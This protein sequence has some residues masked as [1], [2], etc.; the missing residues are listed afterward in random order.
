MKDFIRILV[1]VAAAGLLGACGGV[2]AG[3]AQNGSGEAAA[4]P[5]AVAGGW[6]S[7]DWDSGAWSE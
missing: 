7:W 3:A 2:G 4:P 5:V 6:D 1:V